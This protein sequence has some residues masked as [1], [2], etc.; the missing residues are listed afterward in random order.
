MSSVGAWHSGKSPRLFSGFTCRMLCPY[1]VLR[2]GN[3]LRFHIAQYFP[4]LIV[5][6]AIALPIAPI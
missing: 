4:Q 6:G 1:A 3:E 2:R 5:E